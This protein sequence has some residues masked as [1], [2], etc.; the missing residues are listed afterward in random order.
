MR[1][2]DVVLAVVTST[3]SGLLLA[4]I[5]WMLIDIFARGIEPFLVEGLGVLVANPVLSPTAHTY[6]GIGPMLYGT[7]V[8]VG[9]SILM[10]LPLGFFTGLYLYEK[11]DSKFARICRSFLDMLVEAPTICYGVVV[12]FTLVLLTR[13]EAAIFSSLCLTF[14]LVPYVAIQTCDVLKTLPP[15]LKETCYALG[16][17]TW[18]TLRVLIKACTRALV[19][20][21]MVSIARILGET[22]PLLITAS[23]VAYWG[24]WIFNPFT[25]NAPALTT[26]IYFAAFSPYANVEALGWAACLVLTLMTLTLFIVARVLMSR[27]K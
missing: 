10:G 18:H 8:I 15:E 4:L 5:L 27:S 25:R 20:N 6:G 16:M 12:F 1:A 21:I 23:Q 7:L 3:L 26:F 9:L 24:P 14:I 13:T 11:E 17:S 22:G 19:A 2:R